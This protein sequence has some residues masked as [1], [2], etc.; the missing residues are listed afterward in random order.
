MD[1]SFHIDLADLPWQVLA[2]AGGSLYLSLAMLVTRFL[3]RKYVAW[4]RGKMDVPPV[5]LV[6]NTVFVL[7]PIALAFYGVMKSLVG[8]SNF[9]YW[10]AGGKK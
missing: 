6:T 3:G 5:G 1:V 9:T 10:L 7:W 2:G 4:E 8:L